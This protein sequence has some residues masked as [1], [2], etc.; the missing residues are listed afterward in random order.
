MDQ[1]VPI[2]ITKNKQEKLNLNL[3]LSMNTEWISLSKW[4]HLCCSL[5]FLKIGLLYCLF[6]Y[7]LALGSSPQV[8]EE[9]I[10]PLILPASSKASM[11]LVL[12][13]HLN[14][15]L[16]PSLR[17]CPVFNIQ[18]STL[19][20][21]LLLCQ[22]ETL[23]Y[24]TVTPVF[25]SPGTATCL[26]DLIPSL[27]NCALA[28]CEMTGPKQPVPF[29]LNFLPHEIEQPTNT[30]MIS[31]IPPGTLLVPYPILLPLPVPFPIPF[32]MPVQIPLV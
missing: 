11:P 31:L 7:K 25:Q 23:V 20:E 26:Q 28:E 18:T 12:N 8:G 21:N 9:G 2:S 19:L 5:S 24:Y 17:S 1:T 13:Q 10:S 3:I 6:I 30:P 32:P 4:P 22:P 14:S 29:N 15:Q 16:Q 27:S